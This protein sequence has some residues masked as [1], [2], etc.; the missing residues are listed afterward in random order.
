V[1]KFLLATASKAESA[2]VIPRIRKAATDDD[3]WRNVLRQQR[4]GRMLEDLGRS[5][6]SRKTE[7]P[8]R[9][10]IV[11]DDLDAARGMFMLLQ[12]MGHTANYAINGYVAFDV[13][14]SFRPDVILLDLGLP[15]PNGFDVCERIKA[16]PELK[17]ARVIVITGY[18]SEEFRLRSQQAGCEMHLVKPVAASVIEHLLG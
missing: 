7:H 13:A 17:H 6:A 18:A 15:G 10:L 12:D 2:C 16:D 9:V 3:S 11:E 1:P 8:K 5:F 14:R 4:R